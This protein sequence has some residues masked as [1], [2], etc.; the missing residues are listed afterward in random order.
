MNGNAVNTKFLSGGTGEIGAGAIASLN[1][2]K[3]VTGIVL[4][5]GT[6][7]GG[8]ISAGALGILESGGVVTSDGTGGKLTIASGGTFEYVGV[9]ANSV[10]SAIN[11]LPGATFELGSGATFSGAQ[12]DSGITVAVLAGGQNFGGTVISSGALVEIFAGG[13]VSSAV[14]ASGG[15]LLVLAGGTAVDVIIQSGGT[16][17][18]SGGGIF[19]VVSGAADFGALVN[20]GQVNIADGATFTVSAATLT[21][22][23][24]INLLG[25]TT[26]ALL[27]V[28]ANLR[29]SGGG[30]VAM[31]SST[32]D[33]ISIASGVTL[34]NVNNTILGAGII[35]GSGTFIN[36]GTV[37]A[38][39]S[40]GTVHLDA[41]STINRGTMI[42]I[43][44]GAVQIDNAAV[45]F[46]TLEAISGG[47]VAVDNSFTNSKTLEALA[48]GQV[49]IHNGMIANSGGLILASGSGAEVVFQG[50][51]GEVDGGTL[52]TSAGGEIVVQGFGGNVISG[53]TIAAGSLVEI[54][55]G[56]ALTL[57]GTINNSGTVMVD[58]GLSA[59]LLIG[60]PGVR[61][62]GGGTV[63]MGN[64]TPG[65]IRAS[66]RRSD[67]HQRQRHDPRR[68]HD[69][70]RQPDAGEQRHRQC[71]RQCPHHLD[72]RQ[73]HHQCVRRHAGSNRRRLPGGLQHRRQFR[74][75]AGDRRRQRR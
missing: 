41:T 62:Q 65:F 63:S 13:L 11:A 73:Y 7:S 27:Q 2:V 17:I 67:P 55:G 51:G 25:S 35:S 59:V 20:S 10:A 33:Q 74:H 54:G 71:D 52:K 28:D 5:G 53:V 15:R 31:T 68:R 47:F 26:S 43:S 30:K 57:E 34:T 56:G 75:A 45:N 44:G 6:A 8:T 3:G 39:I 22:G 23:G 9:N 60:A 24:A 49:Q 70:R 1:T 4:S 18:N 36:S 21:N 61:L 40:N 46:G 12:V 50:G 14:V 58:L 72:R 32:Q 64:A 29:L 69:R 19:D 16:A 48:N 42:G 66:R 37:S 38:N